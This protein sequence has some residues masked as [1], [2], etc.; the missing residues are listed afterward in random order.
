MTRFLSYL[1]L[2]LALL[3]G[4]QITI[5]GFSGHA[6]FGDISRELYGPG[7][8]FMGSR[9]LEA[10]ASP[11][12]GSVTLLAALSLIAKEFAVKERSWK[13]FFNAL[14]LAIFLSVSA[15]SIY[16]LYLPVWDA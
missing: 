4:G 14:A 11:V 8:P 2:V 5:L 9:F 1:C 16:L 7:A 12:V 10:V 3:F 13:L 6:A 15:T